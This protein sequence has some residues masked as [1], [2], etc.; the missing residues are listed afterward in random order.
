[1]EKK[2]AVIG[3]MGIFALVLLIASASA[4]ERTAYLDD[5]EIKYSYNDASE[6]ESFNLV[7]SI[8]N[9]GNSNKSGIKLELDEDKPFDIR[10]EDTWDIGTL[11]A[12][13][14]KTHSFRIE[15]DEDTPEDVYDLAFTLS[16][17]NK[18]FDDEFE[19]DIKSDSADLI[20][21]QVRS[22]PATISA[23]EQD[24]KIVIKIENLGGGD[25]TFVRV[26]LELPEGFTPSSSYS[27]STNIGTIPAKGSE[28]A[29]FYIDSEKTL[30]SG[31]HKGRL[32][33]EYKSGSENRKEVLEFDLPVKGIP[34]FR[35]ED[36]ETSPGEV[37]IGAA[38]NELTISI[39]NIG[40]EKGEETS[41]RVFENAD[42]PIDFDQ[43]TN[44]V[45][46]LDS[47]EEGMAIFK[48]D[49]L[50]DGKP[51]TYLVKVQVRTL[52]EGNVIVEEFTVPVKIIKSEKSLIQNSWL[53]IIV[54]LVLLVIFFWLFRIGR[55][56][57]KS[58][59]VVEKR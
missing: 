34:Q 8:T 57:K 53:W 16:E 38:G 27:D 55:K 39:K 31:L 3:M 47:G 6:G 35:I 58:E 30:E 9:D 11:N 12:S 19:I 20:V 13:E 48:F 4:I 1:M 32:N 5:Y 51:N 50:P 21:G 37:S 43:K 49:V 24:I 7:V 23:D 42:F 54:T 41:V 18:D 15:I 33:L 52:T 56:R 17:G 2:K 26:K 36:S 45:G 44:F 59:M 10:S 40:Q 25:A 29:T 14:E 22:T 28:E 46:T